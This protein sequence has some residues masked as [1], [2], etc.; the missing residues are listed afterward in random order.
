MGGWSLEQIYYVAAIVGMVFVVVSLIAVFLQLKQNTNAIRINNT[1]KRLKGLTLGWT[2][3]ASDPALCETVVKGLK[4]PSSL[5]AVETTVFYSFF[6]STWWVLQNA[7][8]SFVKP[9][10]GRNR[11]TPRDAC[12]S[13]DVRISVGARPGTLVNKL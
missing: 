8:M 2:Q 11:Q 10:D 7:L 3:I 13:R 9:G 4:D 12:L 5:S 1:D 6:N